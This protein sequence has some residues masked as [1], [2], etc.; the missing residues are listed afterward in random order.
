MGTD[1]PHR[2]SDVADRAG[3]LGP[4]GDRDLNQSATYCQWCLS[5][6]YRARRPK[7]PSRRPRYLLQHEGVSPAVPQAHH[8]RRP[9]VYNKEAGIKKIATET[10]AGQ[11]GSAPRSRGALSASRFF[12]HGAR[13][14]PETVSSRVHGDVW[15]TCVASPSMDTVFGRQVPPPRPTATAASASRFP[16][17]RAAGAG[18][19]NR[20]RFGAQSR[21]PTRRSSVRKPSRR[22][23]WPTTLTSSSAAPVAD[24]TSRASPSRSSGATRG[25]QKVRVVA[26]EPG[27][28]EPDTRR[29]YDFGDTGAAGEKCTRRPIHPAGLHAGGLRYHG[30]APP[31]RISRR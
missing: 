30:M 26:V 25:G 19:T 16:E 20:A 13:V 18:D 31:F 7:R 8:C 17:V 1:D 21:C 2:S 6:L 29:A 27:V 28:P 5:P 23:K 15:R 10:G 12:V 4:S 22:W 24:R 9:G 14:Q 11:W 3:G